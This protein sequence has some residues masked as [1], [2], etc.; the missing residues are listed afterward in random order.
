MSFK[1]FREESQV[2]QSEIEQSEIEQSEQTEE[3]NV[4]EQS[5]DNLFSLY[6]VMLLEVK[7]YLKQLSEDVKYKLEDFKYWFQ[8][9]LTDVEF[10]FNMKQSELQ[11][12]Q[13]GLITKCFFILIGI[14]FCIYLIWF[15][16]IFF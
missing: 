9:R 1:L 12:K 8:L 11:T 2:E 10:A 6:D 5:E 3:Q 4:T 15:L 16:Q 14:F 7:N 13:L